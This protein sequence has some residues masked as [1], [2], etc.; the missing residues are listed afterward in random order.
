MNAIM[1]KMIRA[2]A[3]A[4]YEYGAYIVMAVLMAPMP[5][6]ASLRSFGEIHRKIIPSPKHENGRSITAFIMRRIGRNEVAGG[7]VIRHQP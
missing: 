5:R 3:E 4:I 1:M 7:T 6:V 2:M